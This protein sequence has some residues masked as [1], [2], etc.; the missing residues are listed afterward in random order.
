MQ[1]KNESLT[2]CVFFLV[3]ASEKFP[4]LAGSLASMQFAAKDFTHLK[5]Q[6]AI[7]VGIPLSWP[8]ALLYCAGRSTVLEE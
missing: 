4:S 6:V 5:G 2:L 3:A 7:V 1:Q 8:S